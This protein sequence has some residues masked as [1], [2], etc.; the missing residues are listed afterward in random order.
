MA[1]ALI[2]LVALLL[3]GYRIVIL[4]RA[5]ASALRSLGITLDRWAWKDLSAGIAVGLA[6]VALIFICELSVR[7]A[8]IASVGS[9]RVLLND[10]ATWIMVPVSEEL[11]FRAGLLG[12]L[13][14]L[15]PR[16]SWLAIAISAVVFGAAHTL[17]EGATVIT[18]VGSTIGAF[19]YGWV[20][21]TTTRLWL[22]I[23]LHFAWNYAQGP[24]FGFPLS[25]GLVKQGSVIQLARTGPDLLTGGEYGPEGGLTGLVGRALVLLLLV[26]YLRHMKGPGRVQQPAPV[27]AS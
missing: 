14:V 10:W 2:V 22:P 20:F 21:A 18:V 6:G 7:L 12:G 1:K 26:W 27:T 16:Y 25:G 15:L 8:S 24:L 13:L 19:A 23:G 3:G 4:R 11:V 17:N 9:P 5:G